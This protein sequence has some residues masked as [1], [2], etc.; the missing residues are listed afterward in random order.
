MEIYGFKAYDENFKDRYGLTYELG[1]TYHTNGIVKWHNT[2]FHFCSNPED[3]FRY[4]DAFKPIHLVE[5]KGFGDIRKYN[6][7]YYG[8]YD[9]YVSEN[10][11]LIKEV[12]HEELIE[13]Y[14]NERISDFQ[15]IKVVRDLK[16]TEEDIR[17]ILQVYQ[18]VNDIE[19]YIE[20]FQYNDKERFN[21]K[22]K[23]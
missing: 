8:Y 17:Q 1:K 2:G 18:N 4:V 20:Y 7:E 12:T 14:L 19:N 5:V 3:T 15:I 9:M 21:R 11:E 10:I 22:L 6:D 13:R 23:K 16:L